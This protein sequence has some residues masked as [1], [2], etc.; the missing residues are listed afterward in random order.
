MR[1]AYS[2]QLNDLTV[3]LAA[4]CGLA[5]VAMQRATQA[6]LQADLALAEQVIGEN[7]RIDDMRVQCEGKAFESAREGEE[8][9]R[10]EEPVGS[11]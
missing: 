1:V 10:R 5:E 11:L 7:D 9:H 4:M 3:E 6:L 8:V 2:E